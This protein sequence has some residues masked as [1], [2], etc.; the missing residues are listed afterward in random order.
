MK[1]A[2]WND[3]NFYA[4]RQAVE[5]AHKTLHK[6]IKEFTTI[7]GQCVRPSLTEGA[8]SDW[9]GSD[10]AMAT[11]A[12]SDGASQLFLLTSQVPVHVCVI[13]RTCGIDQGYSAFCALV[14]AVPCMFLILRSPSSP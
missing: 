8:H 9:L 5:K 7:L 1:I 14:I 11:S 3:I 10:G 6:H 2:R 4:M 13:E 12:T